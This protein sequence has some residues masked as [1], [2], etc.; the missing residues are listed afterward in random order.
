MYWARRQVI[1]N[2]A[3]YS[4]NVPVCMLSFHSIFIGYDEHICEMENIFWFLK[5]FWGRWMDF[6]LPLHGNG[7]TLKVHHNMI[8][9]SRLFCAFLL[10]CVMKNF[11]ENLFTEAKSQGLILCK[12]VKYYSS[13]ENGSGKEM[14]H[15]SIEWLFVR[16][17]FCLMILYL[18]WLN[19]TVKYWNKRVSTHTIRERL[20][21]VFF[22][23]NIFD[24][25]IF[26]PCIHY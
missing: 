21:T 20:F 26:V 7:C 6:N 10:C 16:F 11:N 2:V 15:F 14:R 13:L 12:M 18:G 24:K 9:H 1:S 5:Y 25:G 17:F 19:Y 23:L 3:I 4:L 8:C 22:G